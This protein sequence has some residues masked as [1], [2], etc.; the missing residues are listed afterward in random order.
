MGIGSAALVYAAVTALIFRNLLPGLA[1]HIY[2]DL[3]DT[4][5]NASILAWNAKQLPLTEAWW[6]F[7]SFAPLTGV[8]SFTEHLLLLY[9]IASPIVWATG[10]PILAYNVVFLLSPV[11]N[12]VATY[13][14]ARELTQS[15]AAAF[16]AGLAFAFAPYQS[17]QLSHIQEMMSFGMPIALL[18]LHRYVGPAA[19]DFAQARKAGH[20]VRGRD[21][22]RARGGHGV[23]R[24]FDDVRQR[25]REQGAVDGHGRERVGRLDVD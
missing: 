25:A 20:D 11:L 15:R 14:L 10:N 12:G 4:L 17:V 24:V 19:F 13:A 2:S 6:N 22:D 5:L 9:P 3:G 21:R 8:T 7:P 1:T 18:G 23:Q 16:I